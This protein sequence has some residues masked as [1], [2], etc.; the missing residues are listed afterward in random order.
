MHGN[1]IK[2]PNKNEIGIAIIDG[3]EHIIAFDISISD[4]LTLNVTLTEFEELMGFKITP[5]TL[6]LRKDNIRGGLE[7]ALAF[8]IQ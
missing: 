2:L 7:F 3:K 4:M 6:F 8:Y 1:I 5:E